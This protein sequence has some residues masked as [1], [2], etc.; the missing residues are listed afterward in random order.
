MKYA[1]SSWLKNF[2]RSR[3]G[4]KTMLVLLKTCGCSQAKTCR[5]GTNILKF[6]Y[7]FLMQSNSYMLTTRKYKETIWHA[8]QTVIFHSNLTMKW[9]AVLERFCRIQRLIWL[10]FVVSF[11][12]KIGWNVYANMD[13]ICFW[14]HDKFNA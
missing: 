5:Q 2:S 14:F 9:P 1:K 6:F 7:F 12:K 8:S 4:R 3:A 10:W 13:A 11:R